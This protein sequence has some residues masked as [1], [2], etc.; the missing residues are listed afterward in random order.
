MAT[1]IEYDLGEGTKILIE[2]ADEDV[3]GVV[4]A[5]NEGGGMAKIKAKKNFTEALKD[6]RVQAKLLL[7]EIEELDVNEAEVRFGINTVGELGNMAIGK[8]GVGVNYE[9]TLKWQ[10]PVKRDGP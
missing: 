3:G 2:A 8:V 1:Y 7:Q 4:R 9:V 5:S 10:K 6:I